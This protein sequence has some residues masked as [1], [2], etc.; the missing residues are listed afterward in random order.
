MV[1][2]INNAGLPPPGGDQNLGLAVNAVELA[3]FIPT[4]VIVLL[5]IFTR[6]RVTYNFGWDD[7]LIVFA[8]MCNI[9]GASFVFTEVANGMG[10]HRYYLSP[11]TYK[12]FLKYD[13]LDWAQ[14]FVTLAASKISICLFLLRLSNFDNLRFFLKGLISFIVLSHLPLFLLI[15][16]QCNPVATV[17]MVA[18]NPGYPGTCLRK[19]TIEKIVIAQGEPRSTGIACIIRTAWSW[20]ILSNDLSR[21]CLPRLY[22]NSK[23]PD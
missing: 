1:I 17:W 4:C 14:V 3:V 20:Q 11:E 12:K 19:R 7:V 15:V 13:Y 2:N 16:F 18:V 5:R 9:V 10:R 8:Q 6:S 23:A 22:L 21:K